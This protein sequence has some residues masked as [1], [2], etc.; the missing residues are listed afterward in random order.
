MRVTALKPT[1]EGFRLCGSIV[2]RNP[3]QVQE[4]VEVIPIRSV[5]PS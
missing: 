4:Y 5:V 1:L 3:P 2:E